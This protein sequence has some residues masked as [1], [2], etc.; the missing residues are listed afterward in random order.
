MGTEERSMKRRAQVLL[1]GILLLGATALYAQ[2]KERKVSYFYPEDFLTA[3]AVDSTSGLF[4]NPTDTFNVIRD[5]SAVAWLSLRYIP[6]ETRTIQLVW[7]SP[8]G[9]KYAQSAPIT[10]N[11]EEFYRKYVRVWQQIGLRDLDKLG[12]LGQW[13]VVAL[14]NGKPM[15]KEAR[16]TLVR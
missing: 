6:K 14:V 4:T 2:E 16:F 8:R 15:D 7:Y 10:V 13:R 3:T 12:L 11:K 1:A 5:E 9:E